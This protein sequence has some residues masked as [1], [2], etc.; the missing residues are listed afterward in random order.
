LSVTTT[1]Q[2]AVSPAQHSSTTRAISVSDAG[3][4]AV[5]LGAAV[6]DQSTDD[7]TL[8]NQRD[9]GLS[10]IYRELALSDYS[11]AMEHRLGGWLAISREPN[12]VIAQYGELK[13]QVPLLY[14]L[15]VLNACAVT[16]THFRYAP[17]WTTIGFLGVLVATCTWR[18]VRWLRAPGADQIAVHAARAQLV[19]TTVLAGVLGAVFLS[20]S[21]LINQ[22]GGPEEQGHVAL[23]IAVTVI[24]CIFCLTNLP[25]AAMLVTAIVTVPYLLYYVMRGNPVFIAM[26]LNIAL[27]TGVMVRVLLNGFASFTG[28]IRSRSELVLKQEEAQRLSA[29]NAR[30]AHTDVLTGLPNRRDFFAHFED[31]LRAS[32]Q[33][34]QPMAVGVL[35]LD[36]FKA[37][38]DTYG[39]AIGDGLLVLVANRLADFAG[40]NVMISRLGGDEF[41]VLFTGHVGDLR[42]RGQ[43]ICDALAQPFQIEGNAISIGCSAGIALFPEAGD[44]VHE[45]F[46]RSDYAA[47]HMKT[48]SPG[49]CALFSLEHE[50][51]IRSER[52][53]ETAL[54]AADLDH[55]LNVRYQPIMC[56]RTQTVLSV[57][58]LGRWTSP[59]VGIVPP[60]VFIVAAEK[61]GTIHAVTLALFKKALADFALMPDTIRL[62]FNLSAK[63]IISPE[64]LEQL[65]ALIEAQGIDPKRITFEL[66]ETA[67]M[68]D[69]PAAVRGIQALRALGSRF[70]LDDFG[71][72]Y[73]SLGHLRRLPFDEVKLDRSFVENVYDPSGRNILS[74]I[75]T[76]CRTLELDCVA[77][78]VERE[79]QLLWLASLGCQRAQGYYFARPM[80]AEEL[81]AW[82]L[83]QVP[84]H[85]APESLN[86]AA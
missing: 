68:R 4:L 28:N 38:N 50:T 21:L 13:R 44:S 53:V 22:Y 70:A 29:E 10:F 75:L 62:S 46:D 83:T 39:H 64:T 45:L 63:D 26:G 76:L 36:R 85:P 51:L 43:A 8:A 23:F 3:L 27:V 33:N 11:I 73:S 35:D 19:S 7:Q 67:L 71:I 82:L 61:L 1:C 42:A 32:K 77:E 9:G 47:Y 56:I 6:T 12:I 18:T 74:G 5:V 14:T 20:W 59:A 65:T 16:Y 40:Q 25:S 58:A 79:A 48:T 54:L 17:L 31:Y 49:G 55:E 80:T 78:G 52:A 34:E 15:L 81:A 69:F 86:Q 57:E 41:G 60:D 24:G 66:T 30:L 84:S 37:V 72:G 2:T